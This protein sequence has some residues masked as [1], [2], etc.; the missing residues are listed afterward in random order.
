MPDRVSIDR[1]EF[2]AFVAENRELVQRY[3]K[4]LD[5]QKLLEKLDD[6]RNL[7]KDLE[8]KLRRAEQKISS[9]EQR[10]GLEVQEGDGALRKAR[11]KFEQRNPLQRCCDERSPGKVD[12]KKTEI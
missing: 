10:A 4:L 9:L 6:L 1:K 11:D 12:G 8:E 7:N 2:Q 5:Y 3:Q